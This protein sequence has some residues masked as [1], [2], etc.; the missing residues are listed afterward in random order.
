[1]LAVSQIPA[2]QAGMQHAM[3]STCA[4]TPLFIPRCMYK[5]IF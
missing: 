1:M 5:S 4:I 2:M 3:K